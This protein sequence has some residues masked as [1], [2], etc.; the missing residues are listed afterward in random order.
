M[1]SSIPHWD[2]SNVYP[3]LDSTEF[4][5]AVSSLTSQI[6]ENENFFAARIPQLAVE[7][8]TAV[9]AEQLEQAILLF[10]RTGELASTINAFIYSFVSTDS[11]DRNARRQ[12][13]EYEQLDIRV[14]RSLT[15][16]QAWVRSFDARLMEI[17]Q[18]KPTNAS[19]AFA[20]QEA[21]NQAKYLMGDLEE[22]LAAELSLSGI[23]AWSKLQG[24][25]TSQLTTDFELDGE[26]Q[27][28]PLPA[29]INLHS[30]PDE[31]V[32]RR[33][34][35]AEIRMLELVDE[36]LAACMNGVKGAQ[37]TLNHRR[38]RKDAIHS[39]LDDAR[40]D[41]STLDAMLSAM[42]DS[43]PSFRSYF[44]AKAKKLGKS[45]LAWWDLFAPVG[46]QGQS[47]SFEQAQ[48]FI[49]N[50]FAGF[51][52]ELE[53]LARTAFES[54]WIDAEP[55]SGKRGGA[56][57][58]GLPGVKQSRILCNFDGTLDQ[59]TTIAHELGHAFHN[60]CMYQAD[61]TTLQRRTPMTLAET[62]SILCETIVMQAA[63]KKAKTPGEELFILET[64][65]SGDAQIIVDIS[66]RYLFEKEVF[67]RRAKA[68]LSP[69][70]FS[71]IMIDAQTATYGDGLDSST[72]N[73]MMW[74]WK[75]HYYRDDLAFYNFPYAFG[76]LFG[77]GLYG[78]Y[79]QQGQA[80]LTDYQ[81]LLAST[82]EA[83]ATDLAKRFGFDLK[84]RK[85]WDNSL[86]IIKARVRRY[87]EL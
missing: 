43:F 46:E 23:I 76:S 6:V 42:W 16:F 19:H 54:N 29:V 82:G 35:E 18:A 67:E 34:Y 59:V 44:H 38:G 8:S 27:S 12:L 63:W 41:Q 85:F 52:P 70:E 26:I 56:F 72:L 74:A 48:E 55:R 51:S 87:I 68:E 60:H 21:A 25:I 24:T 9:L 53:S 33:A 62:A 81:K 65:L 71:N 73:P 58:M 75:P 78:I 40:I 7:E 57:C 80:F 30:H 84:D 69:D 4:E 61:K 36:P 22:D 14:Q 83:N 10:N 32:R 13:S 11:R 66:S 79:Q 49:L 5:S 2:L 64:M 31:Q 1:A 28:L 3:S 45:K 20:I 86:D 47:F 17:I 15:K 39:A 77:I 50:N 37:Q